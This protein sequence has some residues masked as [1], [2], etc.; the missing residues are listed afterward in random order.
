[1]LS[2]DKQLK[3]FDDPPEGSRLC[4]VATNVAETSLTIPG[5]RYVIDCGMVKARAYVAKLGMDILTVMPIAQAQARQRSGRAGRTQPGICYRLYTENDFLALQTTFPPDILRVNLASVILTLKTIGIDNIVEFN[6]IQKPPVEAFRRALTELFLLGA[7]TPN[8]SLS[9]L[10]KRMAMFPLDPMISKVLILS[11]DY[12]CS[13]EVL[14]IVA[15][16][17]TENIIKTPPST[18]EEAIALAQKAIEGLASPYGDHIMY[19]NIFQTYSE[20]TNKKIW[21]KNNFINFKAMQK[22]TE[23][24]K[25][26]LDYWFSI[27]WEIESQAN[28]DSLESIRK[29][30]AASFISRTAISQPD[31]SY[32]TQ[33]DHKRVFIHP[34]SCLF[35]K[36]A[37]II[38]YN[39]LV[40]TTKEY[41]R[42]I[43]TIEK[44]WFLELQPM[45]QKLQNSSINNSAV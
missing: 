45:M 17:S 35:Q 8:G 3:I 37:E 10:G 33:L 34:A 25:Q 32:Y 15:M 13:K 29:C 43:L 41:M 42:D 21:C 19:L 28:E 6:Y 7:L 23:V 1:M 26:L 39:D 11:K 30:F 5:I 12:R 22:V 4:V 18:D 20:E 44:D 38:I 16:L 27:D 40:L 14:A 9:E 36:K 31:G 24:H 2:P